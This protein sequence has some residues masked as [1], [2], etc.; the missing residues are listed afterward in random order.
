MKEMSNYSSFQLLLPSAILYIIPE[1]TNN[2]CISV[3]SN[4]ASKLMFNSSERKFTLCIEY[5]SFEPMRDLSISV[6]TEIIST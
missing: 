1:F 3:I 6:H 4:C 5:K 2:G